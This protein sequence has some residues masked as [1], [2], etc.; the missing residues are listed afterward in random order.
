MER[1]GEREVPSV[2]GTIEG[3]D[4]KHL[5]RYRWAALYT[6]NKKVYDVACGTGY[7][8]LLLGAS[9]YKGFDYSPE[10][11]DYANKYYATIKSVS[12]SVADACNMPE[13]LDTTEVIV[14]FETVEH[15]KDPEVFLHW[16]ANHGKV[17]LISTPIRH[18]FGR[19]HFHLFEYRLS[20]FIDVLNKYF[21]SV[22]M[23][24]QKQGGEI[25]YPCRPE[26]KGVAIAVCQ[27]L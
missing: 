4:E 17:L 11:V 15:L 18:S 20:Q 27:V 7:G 19:S 1:T 16:C 26:D 23:F 12:F 3:V 14:S 22:Q 6:R 2:P 25:V 5:Q 8:S 10:T 24:V 21:V 9:E 13:E